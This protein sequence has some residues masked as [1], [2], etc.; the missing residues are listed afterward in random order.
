MTIEPLRYLEMKAESRVDSARK[1]LQ[2]NIEWTIR[3]L[4]EEL[5]RLQESDE[6]H[7]ISWSAMNDLP[8]NAEEFRQAKAV[9]GEIKSVQ[10]I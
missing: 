8:K 3:H 5:Q 7:T 4:Q 6:A 9:L 10:K 2:Q 1:T